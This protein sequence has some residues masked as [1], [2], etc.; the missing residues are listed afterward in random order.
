MLLYCCGCCGG[1]QFGDD[2][3]GHGG[4][5]GAVGDSNYGYGNLV[6]VVRATEVVM[7]TA[8][9]V[10]VMVRLVTVILVM[11]MWWWGLG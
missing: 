5:D 2:H 11:V 6:V 1:N 3:S 8:D 4:G 9:M 7:V 10:V